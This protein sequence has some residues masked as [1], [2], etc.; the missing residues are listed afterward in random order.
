MYWWVSPTTAAIRQADADAGPWTDSLMT[1]AG[2]GVD[3]TGPAG[4][5]L[6]LFRSPLKPKFWQLGLAGLP[7]STVVR[8]LKLASGLNL[9]VEPRP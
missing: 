2:A 4:P 8:T 3:A 9:A 7:S 6:R 5:K 1:T